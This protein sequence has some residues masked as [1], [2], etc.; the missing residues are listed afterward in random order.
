[1]QEFDII[2]RNACANGSYIC[3]IGIKNEVISALGL[4]L[5]ATED[6]E[7]ID[8][9]GAVVTPGGVDGHVHLAQDRSPRACE[10]GY[11]SADTSKS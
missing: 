8:C 3:D 6:T 9:K 1:M 7:V 11:V 2:L 4:G 5:I 10:A